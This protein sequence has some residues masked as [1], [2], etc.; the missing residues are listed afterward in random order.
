[1]T[2]PLAGG[3]RRID[4]VLAEDYLADLPGRDTDEVRSMRREAQQEE[5]DLSYVRR[6]LQGRMDILRAERARRTAKAARGRSSRTCPR[7]WPTPSAPTAGSAA[8]ST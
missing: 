5:A 6:M 1:M 8:S 7:C 3:R 4:R 2:E